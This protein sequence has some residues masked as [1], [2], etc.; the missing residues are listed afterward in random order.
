MSESLDRYLVKS[1]SLDDSANQRALSI[2]S[3]TESEDDTENISRNDSC[4][5]KGLHEIL[6][7]SNA[8]AR[9]TP[10]STHSGIS[11][12]LRSRL[13][14]KNKDDWHS[15]DSSVQNLLSYLRLQKSGSLESVRT[16][17]HVIDRLCRETEIVP[18]KLVLL[19]RHQIEALVQRYC[20]QLMEQSRLRGRSARSAITE[21]ACLK[22]FFACNGFNKQNGS[23]LRV[24]SY[25]QPPRT[26]NR[27]EYTPSLTQGL[28]MAQ[29][30]GNKRDR[31]IILVLI[32]TGLRNSALRALTV[33]DI[34][35]ELKEE[36]KTLLINIEA[37]WND[38]ISGACKN[39]IPYYTFTARITTEAIDSMLQERKVTFGSY[40][41]EEP[42]FVSNYN[43]ISP[44]QRRTKTLTSRQ[45]QVIVHEAALAAD[46]PQNKN[47]HVH[48]MRKV[49][50]SILRSPLADGSAM[51]SK[52]QEFLMGHILPGSQD[53]YYDRSKV[54]KMRGLYS[55]LVFE[56]RSPAQALS[57]EAIR[58][59]AKILGVDLSK[60][61]AA[62]E[63][64]LGRQLSGK[65]KRRHWKK[66]SN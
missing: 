6:V 66:R 2:T 59:I 65:K 42:L 28:D 57:L 44:S 32:T 54:E 27:P 15:E 19:Q 35:A 49:F 24:K 34:D 16:Y 1:Q 33:G 13:Q 22:T 10:L 51:D 20:D 36:K 11:N 5:K 9:L 47:V 48:S 39:C 38:R 63:K 21:L 30:C 62:K 29:R 46:I 31:A 40:S 14:L 43:Q 17:C 8:S 52:D 12:S 56:D 60:V 7:S 53:N 37:N 18:S 26:T 25:H 50:E 41:A 61:K 23:E 58:K 4:V 55:K 45:L 3:K 64:E